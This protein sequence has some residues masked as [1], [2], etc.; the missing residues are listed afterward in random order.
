MRKFIV[1]LVILLGAMF[2]FSHFAGLKGILDT[3]KDGDWHYLSLAIVLE[4]LWL[5]NQGA[6]FQAIFRALGVQEKLG[7]LILMAAAANFINIIAPSAGIGGIA[8]FLSEARNR[9]YSSGKAT[10]ATTLFILVDYLAFFM[11]LTLGF[12]VLIRR[13]RLTPTEVTASAILLSIAIGLGVILVLGF[14]SERQLSQVLAWLA[15]LVNRVVAPFRPAA[16]KE[17]LSEE[18]ASSFAHEVADGVREIRHNPR[19]L[20][21]PILLALNGKVL[22][23]LVLFS[24]FVAAKQAASIGTLIAG[25]SI[26]FL[27]TIVSPTPSGVGIVESALTLI[28]NSF[29]I[30][31]G[32]SAIIALTY[33]AF[34]FWLPLVF[35]MVAFNKVCQRN[36]KEG[37]EW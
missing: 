20:A 9:D 7:R 17:Y 11:V 5:L 25:F 13:D 28:L 18:R 10:V 23:I 1:A 22:M 14:H 32:T 12:V 8:V 3:L 15:R 6:T 29:Y 26:A 33:R 34:T 37:E 2:V 36:E 30:P 16:H 19:D 35:G 4:L 21:I 24:V 31:L 27:F